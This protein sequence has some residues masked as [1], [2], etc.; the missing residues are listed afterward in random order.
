MRNL[1]EKLLVTDALKK[2][3]R[4]SRNSFELDI[5]EVLIWIMDQVNSDKLDFTL[6][7]IFYW[8]KSQGRKSI[9]KI[10]IKKIINELWGMNNQRTNSLSYKKIIIEANNKV[11][12]ISSKGRYYSI[13]RNKID[14]LMN[15]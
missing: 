9:E 13:S 10:E 6:N 2:V 15:S 4:Y 8:I 12:R 1:N 7:D 11:K 5:S 14:E 3:I